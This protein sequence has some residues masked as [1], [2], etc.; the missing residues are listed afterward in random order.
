MMKQKIGC[1]VSADTKR[2]LD[3]AAIANGTTLSEEVERLLR[4]S[5]E[6]DEMWKNIEALGLK[7]YVTWR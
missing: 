7:P 1:V 2:K 4:L 3:A 5:F 6:Y